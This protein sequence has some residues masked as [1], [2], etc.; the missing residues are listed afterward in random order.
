[1]WKIKKIIFLI[2][3]VLILVVGG[4]FFW[5][6]K[7]EI[8]GSPKDYVIRET[9][10]GKIAE[11]RRAG[12]TVKIPEGWVEKK[13]EFLEGS[14]VFDTP[15]IE[16]RWEDEMVKPPLEKGCTIEATV[17]YKKMNF[18]KIREEIKEIHAGLGIK[19]EQFEMVTIDNRQV[20]ENTFDSK[21]LGPGMA[22]YFINKNKLYSFAVYWAPNEKERCVQEFNK[23]LETVS[24]Y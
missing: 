4:G 10:E 20:L 2:V 16:G 13:I 12:L 18:D 14:V 19:S 5:W 3:I 6:Q 15:D 17:V 11:N 24:T 22:A 7:R 1:M 8:K 21:F 9:K 23:F